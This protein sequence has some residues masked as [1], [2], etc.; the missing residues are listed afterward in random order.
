MIQIGL[1]LNVTT[2]TW[3]PALVLINCV[4][5]KYSQNFSETLF[6]ICK[7]EVSMFQMVLRKINSIFHHRGQ[8]IEV[9]QQF[10]FQKSPT[11]LFSKEKKSAG[12]S[13]GLSIGS[14]E[15]VKS[16]IIPRFLVWMIKKVWCHLQRQS[17][18][19]R[20]QMGWYGSRW[21]CWV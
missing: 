5:M 14:E 4:N 16:D 11:K 15:R 19:E 9:T 10:L 21:F 17:K 6:S 7:T 3:I 20:E 2:W 12:F 18:L 1:S 13:Y 8:H